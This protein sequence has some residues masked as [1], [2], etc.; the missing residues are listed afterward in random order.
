MGSKDDNKLAYDWERP[1]QALDLPDFWMAQFPLTNEQYAQYASKEKHP[2][3]GWA[4]KKNHPV[5]N[6]SWN[7]AV[8]YCK[9]FNEQ[10]KTQLRANGLTLHL[11]TEAQWE[12]AARGEYGNEW[13]WGNEFDKNKCNS[14]EGK[15]KGTTPVDAYPSGASPYGVMDMVGNVWE[16]THTLF[17]EYP[18]KAEDG[19]ESEKVAESRAMRGGSFDLNRQAARCAS[20]YSGLPN[21]RNK[22]VSFRL[23]V[24]PIS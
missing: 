16:W 14:N 18:Y 19:R 15:K 9:W 21:N 12:K 7:D 6:V 5:V 20:R 1:Q 11:P 8:A 3:E 10:H 2:V 4:K 17:K 23:C 22:I 24:S 13:P